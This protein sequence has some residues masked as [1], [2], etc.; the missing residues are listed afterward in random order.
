MVSRSWLVVFCGCVVHLTLGSLVFSQGSLAPYILSYTLTR[1]LD[2]NQDGVAEYIL[3]VLTTAVLIGQGSALLAGGILSRRIG[4]RLTTLIGC[5]I[6]SL[7]VL[8]TAATIRVSFW[9]V[10]VSYGFVVGVGV[11]LAYIGP[12]SAAMR[13]LPAWKGLANGFVLAGYGLGPVLLTPVQVFFINPLNLHSNV[14]KRNTQTYMDPELLDR[15]PNLFLILGVVYM[16]VQ[17]LATIFIVDPPQGVPPK[18]F[19]RQL[20]WLIRPN[21]SFKCQYC[22]KKDMSQVAYS[23]VEPSQ[24]DIVSNNFSKEDCHRGNPLSETTPILSAEETDPFPK[25]KSISKRLTSSS[26][27][28]EREPASRPVISVYQPNSLTPFQ[29]LKRCDFFAL[30][31]EMFCISQAVVFVLSNHKSIGSSLGV[32]DHNYAYIG[33]LCGVFNTLGRP[34]WGAFS[35]FTTFKFAFVI[36][37]SVMSVTVLTLP[38]AISIHEWMFI[39]WVWVFYFC[40]GGV[41]TLMPTGVTRWY[42]LEYAAINYGMV[43]TANALT[44]VLA[45]ILFPVMIYFLTP[46]YSS[47]IIAIVCTIAVLLALCV[48][49]KKFVL[50]PPA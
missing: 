46:I 12:L 19:C 31:L 33:A 15:V 9:M 29:V 30:W 23:R 1:S 5:S 28:H 40:V 14:T 22:A 34:F 42:G 47:L 26:Q 25:S 13:W 2:E 11:G 24:A 39:V 17:L 37:S 44:G 18:G 7:G 3:P 43:F 45:S 4:P 49:E 38:A 32:R 50:L 48:K 20:L 35:D 6:A 10:I 16:A 41:F 36:V 21:F 8:L 27:I